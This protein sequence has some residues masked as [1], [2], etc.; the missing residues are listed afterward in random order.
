MRRQRRTTVDDL[1]VNGIELTEE[2]LRLAG[3]GQYQHV[4]Q[5]VTYDYQNKVCNSD[6]DPVMHVAKVVP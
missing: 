2:H 3:G 1:P 5:G 4:T 6:Q